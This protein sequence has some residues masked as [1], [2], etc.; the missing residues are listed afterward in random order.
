MRE[1]SPPNE[2]RFKNMFEKFLREGNFSAFDIKAREYHELLQ[3][4][5]QITVADMQIE[6][7][8]KEK[9]NFLLRVI[10]ILTD[11]VEGTGVDLLYLL[12]K[13]DRYVELPLLMLL[14]HLKKTARSINKIID[15]VGSEKYSE[16]F[17]DVVDE[18]QPLIYDMIQETF[19]E[20][21]RF[22]CLFLT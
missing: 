20:R 15:D 13:Y 7:N 11:I 2:K 6:D 8:D 5:E 4:R 22:N 21:V 14:E 19:E 17:G 1:L 9:A 3:I 16:S 10:C 18:L 12:K